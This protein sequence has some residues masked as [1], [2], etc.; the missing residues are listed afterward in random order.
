L[1]YREPPADFTSCQG[2]GETGAPTMTG[3][4]GLETPPDPAVTMAGAPLGVI[5]V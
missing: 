3:N 2:Q 4:I 1:L 5:P